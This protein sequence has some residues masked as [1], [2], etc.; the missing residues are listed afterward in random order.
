VGCCP[1]I[2]FFAP[3]GHSSAHIHLHKRYRNEAQQRTHSHHPCRQPDPPANLQEF[4]RAKQSGKPY[5]EQGFQTC[6]AQSVAEVV[7]RQA[8]AGIDVVSD[9]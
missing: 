9:G 8:D 3:A 6:L 5:D 7:K 2:A 1:H 4:L